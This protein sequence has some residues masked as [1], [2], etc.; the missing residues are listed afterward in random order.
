ML[1]SCRNQSI[2]F[3]KIHLTGFYLNVTLTRNGLSY[4]IHEAQGFSHTTDIARKI[5]QIAFT[6]EISL[7]KDTWLLG[8]WKGLKER[9]P[10]WNSYLFALPMQLY[11]RWH[12]ELNVQKNLE[13]HEPY[14]YMMQ[15]CRVLSQWSF[16]NCK[17]EL[18]WYSVNMVCLYDTLLFSFC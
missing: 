7:N 15:V 16:E 5:L 18:K 6:R 14:M 13:Y 1:H 12:F 8:G 17:M 9:L 3:H 2:D 11:V 4:T 10:N